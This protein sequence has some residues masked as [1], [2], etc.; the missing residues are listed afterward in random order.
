MRWDEMR[1]DEMKWHFLILLLILSNLILNKFKKVSFL[2]YYHHLMRS[3]RKKV[4]IS[5]I[6]ST[7]STFLPV[8]FNPNFL[9][10]CFI[11]KTVT[12]EKSIEP[13][14]VKKESLVADMAE[15]QPELALL[16][17]EPGATEEALE[18][19]WLSWAEFGAGEGLQKWLG[20]INGTL[21]PTPVVFVWDVWLVGVKGAMGSLTV[22][23]TGIAPGWA[24]GK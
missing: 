14:A 9:K 21:T 12:L 17:D 1:W 22:T 15:N 2:F 11:S 8:E 6:R 18:G 13:A 7:S 4:S 10:S 24:G 3:W 16:I 20:S 5:R 19:T 23:F